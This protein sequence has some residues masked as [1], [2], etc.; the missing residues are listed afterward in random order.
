MNKSRYA[1]LARLPV[2]VGPP[3][4]RILI[5]VSELHRVSPAERRRS[6]LVLLAPALI[7]LALGV[8]PL[9]T[10]RGIGWTLVGSVVIALSAVLLAMSVG[11]RRSAVAD[12]A[13]AAEVAL[14]AQ[15]SAAVPCGESCGSQGCSTDSC[16]VKSLPRF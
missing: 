11:L 8:V 13:A 9:V 7:L 12:E 4:R 10:S 14:D 2:S 15:L 3:T 16:A 6:A 1:H 5:G